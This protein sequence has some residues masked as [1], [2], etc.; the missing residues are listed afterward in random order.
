MYT[1]ARNYGLTLASG[2]K[3]VEILKKNPS[4]E[5]DKYDDDDLAHMRKY[6]TVF[7]CLLAV[8]C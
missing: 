6:V 5:P 7:T 3:I 2:R 1:M 4:K 8:R